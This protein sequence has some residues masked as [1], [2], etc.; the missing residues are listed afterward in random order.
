VLGFAP[1]MPMVLVSIVLM[2]AVSLA[3]A[4]SSAATIARY[5]A[6]SRA[7]AGV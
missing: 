3:T 7:A 1:V 2:A 5:H 4:P 6:P